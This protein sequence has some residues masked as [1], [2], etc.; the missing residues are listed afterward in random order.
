[1]AGLPPEYA[2][3]HPGTA[4]PEKFWPAANWAD[5]VDRLVRRH[6]LPVVLTG[7]GNRAEMAH[8]AE[9]RAGLKVPVI[10]LAGTLSLP[11][12]AAAIA[13]ARI[14]LGPDTAA[15]HLA[16]SFRRPQVV[17]YGPTN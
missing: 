5:V 16:A 8:L 3:V 14:A 6:N 7:S 11:G 17:L 9:I 4:R 10:D 1:V 2:L 13:G 12:L 15:M